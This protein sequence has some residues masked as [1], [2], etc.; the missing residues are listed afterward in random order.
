[1]ETHAR[2]FLP[3]HISAIGSVITLGN[4][5][6]SNPS[7]PGTPYHIEMA[8]RDGDENGPGRRPRVNQPAVADGQGPADWS[9]GEDDV[10]DDIVNDDDA[11]EGRVHHMFSRILNLR[12]FFSRNLVKVFLLRSKLEIKNAD[13]TDKYDNCNRKKIVDSLIQ[14]L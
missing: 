13:K 12:F 11:E 2:T 7:A 6:K 14:D 1:M 9:D 8:P 4:S 5:F 3:L 10:D